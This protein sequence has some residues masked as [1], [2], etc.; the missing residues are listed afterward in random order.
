M[1]LQDHLDRSILICQAHL[2]D[3]HQDLEVS[4]IRDGV[5]HNNK[6]VGMLLHHRAAGEDRTTS[7]LGLV[8]AHIQEILQEDTVDLKTISIRDHIHR[9]VG[10]MVVGT[11]TQVDGIRDLLSMAVQHQEAQLDQE[12]QCM[13]REDCHSEDTMEKLARMVDKEEELV[14]DAKE[15]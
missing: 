8:K 3:H 14:Q 5:N 13:V 15:K 1:L 6:E 2:K 7:D 10:I 11:I 4:A 9:E 12:F